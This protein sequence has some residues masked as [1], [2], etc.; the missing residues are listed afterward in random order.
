MT[1]R[2]TAAIPKLASLDIERS[3]AFYGR[4]DFTRFAVYPDYGIVE[5]DGVQIHLRL[6]DD[7]N[8]P[9]STGCRINV[10]DVAE[11]NDTFSRLG[12]VHSNGALSIKPWGWREFSITDIDGNLITFAE[13]PA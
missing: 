11:L 8:I 13:R 4:L 5:R 2:L 12:A 9:L 10:D 3:I 1:A 6:C 7:P